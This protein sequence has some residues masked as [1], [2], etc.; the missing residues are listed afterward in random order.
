MPGSD[1][2]KQPL[3]CYIAPGCSSR[4]TASGTVSWP[5]FSRVM[6]RALKHKYIVGEPVYFTASNVARPAASGTDELLKQLPPGADDC[7]YRIKSSTDPF[8]RVARES[9]LDVS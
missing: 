8:E 5:A 2:P 3:A 4:P 6:E 7:Q 1:W 9:E